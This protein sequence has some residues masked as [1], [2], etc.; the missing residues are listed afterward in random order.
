MLDF[1]KEVIF[2]KLIGIVCSNDN[3]KSSCNDRTSDILV[4]ISSK[5]SDILISNKANLVISSIMSC[6]FSHQVLLLDHAIF[7]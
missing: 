5:S 3:L 4:V 6:V 2:S 7:S 1:P